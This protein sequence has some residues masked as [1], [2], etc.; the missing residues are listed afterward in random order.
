MLSWRHKFVDIHIRCYF[1]DQTFKLDTLTVMR[2]PGSTQ[3][4]CFLCSFS[5]MY[6]ILH[7][8][9]S[10]H[11]SGDGFQFGLIKRKHTRTHK[12]SQVSPDAHTHIHSYECRRRRSS[13][14]SSQTHN[15]AQSRGTHSSGLNDSNTQLSKAAKKSGLESFCL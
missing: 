12:Q 5:L 9:T 2:S 7:A 14:S 1:D 15:P 3:K 13:S 6:L 4:P 10:Q 8:A 11:P